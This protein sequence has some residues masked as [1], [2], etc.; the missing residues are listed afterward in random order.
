MMKSSDRDLFTK[1]NALPDE[2]RADLLDFLGGSEMSP[3][4]IEERE[5]AISA[6]IA[7]KHSLRSDRRH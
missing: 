4:E 6:S 3:D 5:D 7:M 1:L 2:K